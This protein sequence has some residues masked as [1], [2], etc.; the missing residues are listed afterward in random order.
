MARS[1]ER[2]R[3]HCST[4]KATQRSGRSGAR[5]CSPRRKGGATAGGRRS[6]P[7]DRAGDARE[8]KAVNPEF[9]REQAL[10]IWRDDPIVLQEALREMLKLSVEPAGIVIRATCSL[11]TRWRSGN[12]WPQG[13]PMTV[14]VPVIRQRRTKIVATIGPATSDASRLR[15]LIEA[16]VDVVRLN[17]SH[18]THD[19]HKRMIVSTRSIST[20]WA[21]RSRFCRTSGAAAAHRDLQGQ[22]GHAS[23]RPDIHAD[24]AAVKARQRSS[25][26][27][28][29][30]PEEVHPGNAVLLDD[31]RIRLQVTEVKAPTCA[32]AWRQAVPSPRARNQSARSEP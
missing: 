18:G 31:G 20:E 14:H 22:R 30:L 24:H 6:H 1:R 10:G 19:E 12:C 23:P 9:A 16:G 27:L 17:F 26:Q 11:I 8:P 7:A 29:Q 21:V 28:P 5:T 32:A 3:V 25:R 13:K 15:A 2:R 4:R